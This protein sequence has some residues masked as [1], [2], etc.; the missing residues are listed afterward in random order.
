MADERLRT[1][2]AVDLLVERALAALP[3]GSVPRPLVVE[4]ARALL[5][6]ERA[7]LGADPAR[8]P[9]DAELRVARVLD[10]ARALA[11][12][13][14]ERL[15]NATGIVLHTNLGR[16]PLSEAAVQAL[17]EAARG[18]LALEYD[19]A[20]GRRSERAIGVERWLCR[21]TGAEAGLVV[22]NGAAALLLAVSA[23]AQGKAVLVSRGELV[24]I[25]GSFRLPAILEK[26]GCRLVEVGTTNRT[27][28]DDYRRAL[29]PEVA[30]LLRVH[31]SNFRMVGF[32][33]RPTRGE[34]AGLAREVGLPLV[35][36]IGSGALYD[37][38][39]MGFEHEPTVVESLTEGAD[40]VTFSGDKLLGGPQA[41][42]AV[43][44][45]EWVALLKRDP[46]ARAL[47]VDKLTIAALEATL[48]AYVE[49]GRARRE[50]PAVAMLAAP[51]QAIE[52]H[53]LR[54]RDILRDALAG[55]RLDAPLDIEVVA[56]AGEVGGGALPGAVLP[57]AAV[58][59]SGAG[60]SAAA[61][62]RRLRRGRPPVIARIREERVLLDA[63]TL[64]FED[65]DLVARLVR[66]A[67]E[68]P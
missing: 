44:R 13:V 37:T 21:L 33:E 46:L 36:D 57:T 29:T 58:A 68:A 42:L 40:V 43:G 11:H 48:A 4:A 19:V 54:L 10:Q 9:E 14:Q 8:A 34:L 52:S 1:L 49:P 67:V 2:P 27:R 47:R 38:A 51:L 65:P 56:E 32:H 50:L 59:L 28:L 12:P 23:L 53:A 31:P 30:L 5:A 3:A 35:E 64:L 61:L 15:V 7:A 6:A 26:A 20:G 62:E 66:A 55:V 16:A 39:E 63:R 41:G 45:R 18:Y 17:G 60:R 24:E 25:G 22:N